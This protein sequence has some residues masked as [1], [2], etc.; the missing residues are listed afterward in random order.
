MIKVEINKIAMKFMF[1][2]YLTLLVP[3]QMV[4]QIK[5]VPSLH[6]K[7]KCIEHSYLEVTNT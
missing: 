4:G 1:N 5:I 7:N 3:V 2:L 6:V